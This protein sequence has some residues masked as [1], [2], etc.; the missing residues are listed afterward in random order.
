MSEAS[1]KPKER[2]W[3]AVEVVQTSMMDCGPAAL[4][5]LLEGYHVPISYGRLREACQTDV[6]GTSIDTIEEIARQLGLAAEQV[7]VPVDHLFIKESES[8]PGMM[9]VITPNG[10]TH[11]VVVWSQIGPFVQLMDPATGRRWTTASRIAREIYVHQMPVPAGAFEEWARGDDFLV[12][13][14]KRLSQIGA[15]SCVDLLDRA[16]A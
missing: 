15:S 4:K 13:Y 2:R 1:V 5:C 3:L 8:F 12:V 14:R 16:I 6:D 11:F 10:M 9:V 7:M